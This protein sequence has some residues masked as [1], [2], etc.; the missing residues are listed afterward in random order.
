MEYRHIEPYEDGRLNVIIE[1]PK[2]C[3]NKY[4]YDPNLR[5]FKLKKM[6]P[7]GNFFPYNFGFLPNTIA[8][9]GD[10]LDVLVLMD[11]PAWP[12]CLVPCRPLGILLAEQKEKHKKKYRNDRIIAASAASLSYGLVNELEDLGPV[13]LKGIETFFKDYNKNEDKIFT[14]LG[15]GKAKKATQLVNKHNIGQ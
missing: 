6:L 4:D 12:G 10:P 15:W 13:L 7:L 2:G 8:E 9:D 5:L 11:E 1:T 14:P 3:A